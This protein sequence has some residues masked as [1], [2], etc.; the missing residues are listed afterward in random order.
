MELK[1]GR[2]LLCIFILCI[3]YNELKSRTLVSHAMRLKTVVQL[4]L[5]KRVEVRLRFF[6]RFEIK[7]GQDFCHA[8]R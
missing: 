4:P 6:L 8:S 1:S 5:H 3:P 2:P 7:S